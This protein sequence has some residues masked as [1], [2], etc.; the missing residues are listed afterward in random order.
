[1]IIFKIH[2]LYWLMAFICTFC[3]LFKNFIYFSLLIIVHEL[4]HYLGA[5]LYKWK[6]EKIVILPFGGITIFDEILS[7]SLFEE[8]IILILGPLFQIAFYCAYT[9]I[10]GF[11]QIL[12][13]YHYS[14]LVFNLLPIFPLDGFKLLNICFNKLFPFKASHLISIIISHL[15]IIFV[16][17]LTL[18]KGNFIMLLAL[19]FLILKNINEFINHDLIFNKFLLERYLYDINFRKVKILKTE[20]LKKMKREYKHLFYH[21][22]KYETEKSFLKK[23]FDIKHKLC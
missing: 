23:K 4:G 17:I 3:G 22:H 6:V 12:Y 18:Y 8:F 16:F 5:K 15:I 1:M 7:K 9:K 20:N 21:N 2:I 13:N 19:L 14:L 10:F 11:N